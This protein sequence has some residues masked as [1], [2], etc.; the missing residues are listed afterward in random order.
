MD[1]PDERHARRATLARWCCPS[2]RSTIIAAQPRFTSNPHVF[3][4]IGPGATN[5]FGRCKKSLDEAAGVTGWTLH[6]LRRTARSL[7]SRAGVR[8]DIAERVLG[9]AIPGVG[10]IYD[11]HPITI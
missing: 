3:A 10:G 6:D 5:N 9:H 4:G 11:R 2:W 1:D 7:I 8:T